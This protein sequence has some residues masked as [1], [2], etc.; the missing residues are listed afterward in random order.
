MAAKKLTQNGKG[1]SDGRRAPSPS[2]DYCLL[3]LLGERPLHGYE[4]HRELSRKTGLGLVWTVKQA[5]LYA[6]LSKLEGEGLIAAALVAQEGRPPRRVFHLTPRGRT[7]FAEWSMSPASRKDFKLDFLAKLY[8]ARRAGQSA[9]ETLVSAQR[10]SCSAWIDEMR[11]R[12]GSCESGSLDDLVY[13]YRIGQLEATL[14]WL[15]ECAECLGS[16]AAPAACGA[17]AAPRSDS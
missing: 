8:F 3:G 10:G 14:S 11:A 12:S 13:R 1:S 17:P 2:V 6:T 9:A 7:A 15:D 5:Q 16:P 4:L